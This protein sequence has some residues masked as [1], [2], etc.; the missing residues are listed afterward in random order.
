MHDFIISP[1]HA[2][3]GIRAVFEAH[4]RRYLGA[5]RIA[6]ELDGLFAAALERQVRL[7]NTII[8]FCAHIFMSF[9]LFQAYNERGRVFRTSF[10]RRSLGGGRRSRLRSTMCHIYKKIA[11]DRQWFFWPEYPHPFIYDVDPP[12]GI[13][14]LREPKI[15]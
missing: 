13:G 6:V 14:C 7:N 3:G 12:Q 1:L 4:E 2:H 5:K 10:F 9:S 11:Q 15:S 8:I